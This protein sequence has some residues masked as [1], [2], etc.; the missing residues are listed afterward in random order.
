MRH[1]QVPGT[2][3]VDRYVVT[4]HRPA[5]RH[6]HWLDVF[7]NHTRAILAL[8]RHS[9][10]GCFGFHIR[11]GAGPSRGPIRQQDFHQRLLCECSLGRGLDL[12]RRPPGCD[13]PPLLLL[14]DIIQLLEDCADKAEDAAD[15]ARVL[16]FIM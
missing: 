10:P 4:D 13:L 1:W 3:G 5:G 11:R 6:R 15:A 14:R 7:H 2:F 8:H 12:R 9:Y 16:S